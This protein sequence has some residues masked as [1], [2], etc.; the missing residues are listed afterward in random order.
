MTRSSQENIN[1]DALN[2]IVILFQVS[3]NNIDKGILTCPS[4]QCRE[5]VDVNSTKHLL[6]EICGFIIKLSKE[7]QDRLFRYL[8]EPTPE[9][10]DDLS[11]FRHMLQIFQSFLSKRLQLRTGNPGGVYPDVSVIDATKCIAVLC[12]TYY[13][14]CQCQDTHDHIR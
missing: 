4:K 7:E 8:I 13:R 6:Q 5:F 9:D 1:A 2:I 11:Q 3:Q 14:T 10:Q 12:K